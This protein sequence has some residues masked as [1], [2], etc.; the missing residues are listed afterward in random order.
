M[1]D[2]NWPSD[3]QGRPGGPYEHP[4]LEAKPG[5]WDGKWTEFKCRF[6][7]SMKEQGCALI[8]AGLVLLVTLFGMQFFGW[9]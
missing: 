1:S 4:A 7:A 8:I 2:E 9:R 5:F 6:G 3:S